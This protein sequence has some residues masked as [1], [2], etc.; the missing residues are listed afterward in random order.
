MQTIESYKPDTFKPLVLIV[1]GPDRCGKGTFIETVK[2]LVTYSDIIHMHSSKPPGRFFFDIKGN[3]VFLNKAQKIWAKGYNINLLN[4]VDMLL[5]TNSVIILDRSYIGEY[6]Y[7]NLYRNA[8]YTIEDFKKFE[9]D[10]L[11]LDN[12]H[13]VL[14][15]FKD[16]PN[17]LI[18]REDG[19]SHSSKF[20]DKFNELMLFDIL[21]EESKIDNK[22]IVDWSILDFNKTVLTT[23]TESII[24]DWV[25]ERGNINAD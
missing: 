13:Y 20:G 5:K 24:N 16:T 2:S 17:N 23:I 1:E 14:I 3:P 22:I 7:G 15:N 6:V 8:K 4:N 9:Q 18:S 10:Y 19:Q 21:H 12:A 11:K 25:S